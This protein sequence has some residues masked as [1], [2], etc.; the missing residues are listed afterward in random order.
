MGCGQSPVWKTKPAEER[1]TEHPSWAS[2]SCV[3]PGGKVVQAARAAALSATTRRVLR[4]GDYLRVGDERADSG[5]LTSGDGSVGN[6]F[7]VRE[8]VAVEEVEIDAADIGKVWG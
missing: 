5:E 4:M 8:R 6:E 7:A 2:C 3:R 1:L